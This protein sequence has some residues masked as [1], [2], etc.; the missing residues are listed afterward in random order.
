MVGQE[1]LEP[2]KVRGS[3]RPGFMEKEEMNQ[4]ILRDAQSAHSIVISQF[5]LRQRT[6]GVGCSAPVPDCTW[7]FLWNFLPS[8]HDEA[9][10]LLLKNMIKQSTPPSYL[11]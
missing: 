5:A 7:I 8:L 1:C 4:S 2:E 10:V 3:K 9:E 6:V 11:G